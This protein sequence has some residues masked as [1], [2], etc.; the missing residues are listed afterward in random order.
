M[1]ATDVIGLFYPQGNIV[2]VI[3]SKNMYEVR[4]E[5]TVM[6]YCITRFKKMTYLKAL[7]IFTSI[8]NTNL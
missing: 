4:M 5:I 1:E 6:I 3:P 8:L 2:N 7:L